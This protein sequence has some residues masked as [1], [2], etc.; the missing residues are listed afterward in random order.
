MADILQNLR[1]CGR[2]IAPLAA[3]IRELC[4]DDDLAFA[5]TLEGE[6]NAIKAASQAVRMVAAMETLEEGAKA[7]AQRYSA[8]AGDFAARASRARDALAHFMGEIGEKRLTLPE[9][10]ITLAAGSPS[11]A[12]DCDADLLPDQFVRITRQ[13]DRA[14]IKAALTEGHDVPGYALTN[15]RP[16][17]QIRTR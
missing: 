7:L 3:A 14:K 15:A 16:K 2:E 9:A 6:T 17:L 1:D 5:D 10:T 4:G 11:L 12:G 8:R 13:P